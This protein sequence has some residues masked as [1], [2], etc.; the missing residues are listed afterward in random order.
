MLTDLFLPRCS[1]STIQDPDHTE[2]HQQYLGEALWGCM[3]QI[4]PLFPVFILILLNFIQLFSSGYIIEL[5]WWNVFSNFRCVIYQVNF[6]SADLGSELQGFNFQTNIL[7]HIQ[8]LLML[9]LIV[10]NFM[11]LYKN[12]IH[13]IY[14]PIYLCDIIGITSWPF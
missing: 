6:I 4:Y 11:N 10:D 5:G 14:L 1:G 7:K 3:Y 2:W 12:E 9:S 13:C 8:V